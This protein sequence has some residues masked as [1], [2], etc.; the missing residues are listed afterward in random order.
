M[1]RKNNKIWPPLPPHSSIPSRSQTADLAH[2]SLHSFVFQS[3][4][5]LC[6]PLSF[7]LFQFIFYFLGG[8]VLS[9]VMFS[10]TAFTVTPPPLPPSVFPLSFSVLAAPSIL[11]LG[12]SEVWQ[13]CH[14]SL[15]HSLN[16]LTFVLEMTR[17]TVPPCQ[18]GLTRLPGN[19]SSC[20]CAVTVPPC[21]LPVSCPYLDLPPSWD[22]AVSVHVCG[23][24][25][26]SVW[27]CNL[28][29][30]LLILSRC[31]RKRH[32]NGQKFRITGI[33]K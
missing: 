20:W 15:H 25:H 32:E 11:T 16:L 8:G 29:D 1:K 33:I 6:F 3:T 10:F 30:T 22:W 19:K 21:R 2:S 31:E 26:I 13:V 14:G 4:D 17:L 24:V 5:S 18:L 27:E 7:I 28:L 12:L 23:Q 9:L